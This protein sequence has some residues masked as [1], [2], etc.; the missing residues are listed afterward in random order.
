MALVDVVGLLREEVRLG[1]G[2]SLQ[3]HRLVYVAQ[4]CNAGFSVQRLLEIRAAAERVNSDR[5]PQDHQV[6]ILAVYV[7]SAAGGRQLVDVGRACLTLEHVLLAGVDL[8]DHV[9]RFGPGILSI[10]RQGLRL[11]LVGEKGIALVRLK[12]DAVLVQVLE[13]RQRGFRRL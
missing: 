3:N 6:F 8:I 9:L 10:L 11:L 4:A 2:W 13:I 12:S 1:S 7:M 5:V